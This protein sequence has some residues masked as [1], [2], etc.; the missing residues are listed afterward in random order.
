[1]KAQVLEIN[2]N[3]SKGSYKGLEITYKG[4]P[5]D[6]REK[7]P[8]TRFVFDNMPVYGV[9]LDTVTVGDWCD[10]DFVPAKNPKYTDLV[11]IVPVAKPQNT[12]PVL[13]SNIKDPA[14]QDSQE[15][16]GYPSKHHVVASMNWNE[17]QTV[18][19][20][21]EAGR[22]VSISRAVALS[23]ATTLVSALAANAGYTAGNLKKREFMAEEV[24]TT[25]K[26]FYDYLNGD[27]EETVDAS[28][29]IE[30]PPFDQESM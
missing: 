8:T 25:A 22:Q 24:L 27:D 20:D 10:L 7:K 28:G 29:V 1:M 21:L 30:E 11:G 9:I 12:A 4:E 3:A 13:P 16:A 2:L 14:G 26:R 15:V 19:A 23:H 5:Y 6:G 17:K 18:Y